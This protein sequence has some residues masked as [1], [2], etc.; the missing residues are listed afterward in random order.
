MI[1][2]I[3]RPRG[4]TLLLSTLVAAGMILFVVVLA[5]ISTHQMHASMSAVAVIAA[6]Q[7]FGELRPI[8][9]TRDQSATDELSISTAFG[10][11]LMLVSSIGIAIGAQVIAVLLDGILRRRSLGAMVMTV[12]RYTIAFLGAQV[13]YAALRGE[14]LLD[15]NTA[16]SGNDVL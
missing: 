8:R 7:I 11:V 2:D 3:H 9:L 5:T 6:V 15:N 14:S 1:V 13:V 12:A 4:V 10:L 16:F